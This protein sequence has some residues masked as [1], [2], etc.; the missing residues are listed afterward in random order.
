MI[1]PSALAVAEYCHASGRDLIEAV[2]IG[3]EVSLRAGWLILNGGEV[4]TPAGMVANFGAAAL[5]PRRY[6]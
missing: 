2:A 4:I 1:I 5:C 6:A 3:Y